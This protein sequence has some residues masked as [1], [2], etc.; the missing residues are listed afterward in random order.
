LNLVVNQMR[1]KISD[2][3]QVRLARLYL[4]EVS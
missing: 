1:G 3:A 2:T 4:I